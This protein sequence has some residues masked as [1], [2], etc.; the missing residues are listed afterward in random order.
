[1]TTLPA[2]ERFSFTVDGSAMNGARF[3]VNDAFALRSRNLFFVLGDVVEGVVRTG[4]VVQAGPAH[5]P[6]FREAIHAVEFADRVSERRSQVAL[7]FRYRD[8]LELGT[9]QDIPWKDRTLDIPAEP[10]L[11]PCPCCG[12]R[13]MADEERGSYDICPVC[14]W[15]D[16]GVQYRDPDYQGGANTESLN[17]ARAAFIAAHPQ[18]APRPHG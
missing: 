6:S 16:D 3:R 5:R 13:T 12:F 15:E 18:F 8:D 4:M 9:W 14:G 10:I 17:E 2:G 11:H 1:M 7:G